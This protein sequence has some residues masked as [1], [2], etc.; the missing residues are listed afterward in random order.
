MLVTASGNKTLWN[1]SSEQ[2]EPNTPSS[3]R[4]C[5][6]AAVEAGLLMGAHQFG[7]AIGGGNDLPR[8]M[9]PKIAV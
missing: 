3:I 6:T 9:R 7:A 5:A 8:K 2:L 4:R 1:H